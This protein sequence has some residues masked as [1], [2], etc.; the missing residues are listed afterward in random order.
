MKFRNKKKDKNRYRNDE[1]DYD[2]NSYLI[3]DVEE[4]PI[5]DKIILPTDLW[6]KALEVGRETYNEVGFYLIG[7]FRSKTCY[8][9]DLIE[10]DYEEQSGAFI[11]TGIKRAARLRA[12]LPLGLKIVGNMHKHPGFLSYSGTDRRDY[13]RYGRGNSQNAFLIY[14][15]DP[16]DGIAGYTATQD[17]IYKV[18]VE[19]RE[20]EDDEKLINKS[21]TLK[22]D[23]KIISQKSDKIK[24]L[25]FDLIDQLSSE[26]LKNYSR[27]NLF[28][29][30]IKISND[31]QIISVGKNLDLQPKTPV[32]LKGVGFNP[33]LVLRIFLDPDNDL[34]D[35]RDI[36]VH[37]IKVDKRKIDGIRF[38]N[39]G[40]LLPNY[41][42]IG[43]IDSILTWEVI[44]I[45]KK[46]FNLK[47]FKE[48]FNLIS[49]ISISNI[50][51][52]FD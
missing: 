29:D 25:K 38:F 30:G 45:Q 16:Y 20:L 11:E 41:T 39:E 28:E 17:D 24:N 51:G 6:L 48:L 22:I 23:F 26:I 9:Y 43:D 33:D 27:S 19:I 4:K 18:D 14:I 7:L 15:V 35:L 10:F 44:E 46:E 40:E 49:N 21:I 34:Y 13:L 1:E 47:F 37:L 8:I 3:K 32:Y 36:L 50:Y 52:W 12:G 31:E 5:V 2:H 42:L